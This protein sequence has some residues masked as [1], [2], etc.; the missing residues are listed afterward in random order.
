MHNANNHLDTTDTFTFSLRLTKHCRNICYLKI[1]VQVRR[2]LIKSPERFPG[3]LGSIPGQSHI[4]V[5]SV[6]FGHLSCNVFLR[7][8]IIKVFAVLQ[9]L[10]L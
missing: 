8:P 2:F 6:F 3:A 7:S 5:I 4:C 9:T 1:R 10:A